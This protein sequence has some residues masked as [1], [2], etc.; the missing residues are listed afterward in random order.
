MLIITVIPLVIAAVRTPP[1]TVF[2][3]F[4]VIARDA[5]VYEALWRAGWGGDWLFHPAY[6]TESLP[7]VLL[8]PWYLWTGHLAGG[9]PGP[10]LYHGARLLASLALL[11][12][13][14]QLAAQ[15]FRHPAI[16][17][18][19]F[20]LAT[21][22][23]GVGPFVPPGVQLGPVPIQAT[24]MKVPGTAVADLVSMAPHLPLAV[25]LMCWAFIGAL[26]GIRYRRRG[27]IL[28]CLAALLG[29]ELIYPQLA[30]LAVLVI[31]AWAAARRQARGVG[32]ALAG[33]GVLMPYAIYLAAVSHEEVFRTVR[34]SLEVGD[35]FGF[36]VLSHLAASALILV[37]LV[38]RR[39]RGDLWLPVF[40][41]I[42]MTAFMFTPGASNV[43]G[44]S[45]MGSS[46]PF[47]IAATAGL[48]AV[49]RWLRRSTSRR[50]ALA[51]TL[52]MSS[53]FGI[54][55]LAQPLW[56]AAGRLDAY[57]EY[58]PAGEAA[59]LAWLDPRTSRQDIILTTYLDGLFVP[60]QTHARTYTGHPDQ[61]I[62]AAQKADAALSF[63]ERW[64]ED[65]RD[66]FL[67]A[68]G[69]RYVLT[70]VPAQAAALAGDTR[71]RPLRS[72]SGA[73]LFQVVP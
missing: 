63:F 39:I 61:T 6:T 45:F 32:L 30:W 46:I 17:L 67:G 43:V 36:L 71:L 8:Y 52:A 34:A 22:G 7:G 9:L 27:P 66:R 33:G 14:Y 57:A 62:D 24:E 49:L 16:R 70:T 23:G 51:A 56:I 40:W 1:G 48:V 38:K 55:S 64:S 28:G 19:A 12:A 42:G 37:A 60:A 35:P 18:W 44:R 68:N 65:D 21:L 2:T 59:L 5:P 10:W 53:A 69:I 50:R 41:I 29:L 25:A 3:G 72:A 4:V 58:E 20:L 13:T 73:A 15:L 54:F 11:G 31:L 47:G 26:R